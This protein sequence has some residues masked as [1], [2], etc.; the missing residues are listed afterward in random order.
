VSYSEVLTGT[1]A[2]ELLLAGVRVLSIEDL[3]LDFAASSH[4][5]AAAERGAL[6]KTLSEAGA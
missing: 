2:S 4:S 5:R 3:E 1:P 6:A